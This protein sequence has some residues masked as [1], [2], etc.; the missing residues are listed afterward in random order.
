[1]RGFILQ[2]GLSPPTR[3]SQQPVTMQPSQFAELMGRPRTKNL[4]LASPPPL[5]VRRTVVTPKIDSTVPA[6]EQMEEAAQVAPSEDPLAM[7]DL[8]PYVIGSSSSGRRSIA[9]LPGHII[10]EHFKRGCRTRKVAEGAGKQKRGIPV[11]SHPE[12]VPP[13]SSGI[14]SSTEPRGDEGDGHVDASVLGALRRLRKLQR[15][16]G[17][18]VCP[19]LHSGYGCVA[20]YWWWR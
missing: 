20:L 19:V 12:H 8:G 13:A 5:P 15:H 1:M 18:A 11:G 10:R 4:S 3:P 14:T 6:Q 2:Q 9:R 16:G 7:A 17:G